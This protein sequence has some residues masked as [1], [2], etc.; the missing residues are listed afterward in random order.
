MAAVDVP[1]ELVNSLVQ[2]APDHWLKLATVQFRGSGNLAA[3]GFDLAAS[4]Q[5][6][7]VVFAQRR[8]QPARE[9]LEFGQAM[10][11]LLPADWCHYVLTVDVER[12]VTSSYEVGE[13]QEDLDLSASPLRQL[14]KDEVADLTELGQRVY[15]EGGKR[16]FWQR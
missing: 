13:P 11:A 12:V 5:D 4:W 9:H 16:R 2:Y 15:G 3:S 14:L 8:I 7:N 6:G 1:A 10:Q